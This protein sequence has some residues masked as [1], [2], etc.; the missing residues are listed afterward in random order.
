MYYYYWYRY[1]INILEHFQRNFFIPS[2]FLIFTM[3]TTISTTLNQHLVTIAAVV[4]ALLF[5]IIFLRLGWLYRRVNRLLSVGTVFNHSD[6]TPI[7]SIEKALITAAADLT[8]LKKFTTE[9]RQ[10]LTSVEH[11]LKNSVQSIGT[12]RYN[13]FKGTGDGGNNSFSAAFLNEQGD[14]IVV[15]SLY[16][17][18]RISVFG[19]PVTRFTSERELSQEEREAISICQKKTT[20]T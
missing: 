7:V 15:T 13:P 1:F 11:R 9:M 8:E 17:R 6:K 4:I 14:G 19:K 16:T 3:F 12:V 5:I 18:D 10:Y 20:T 2:L